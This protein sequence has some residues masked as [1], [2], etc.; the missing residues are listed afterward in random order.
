MTITPAAPE[1]LYQDRVTALGMTGCGKSTVM[2]AL[3]LSAPGPLLIVDPAD[4]D[5]TAV[6]G[7]V[8]VHGVPRDGKLTEAEL[9]ALTA[10]LEEHREADRLRF[11]PG[12]PERVQE[13]QAVYAWAFNRFPRRT[14]L[15]EARLAAPATGAP[16]AVT[17]Y[18]L[19]GRKRQLGHQAC[20]T[21]PVEVS[22]NLIAQ[23]EHLL[24]W[25]LP[26]PADRKLIAEVLGMDWRELG[27]QMDA[28]E[29]ADGSP[30]ATGFLWWSVRNP[31][32]LL[33][34]PPLE[35]ATC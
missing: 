17:R 32:Q 21:R 27:A 29:K 18:L 16:P 19:W 8:T 9:R 1:V 11:V 4:S 6:P 5:A 14:W 34:C 20:H 3:A 7:A 10:Q 15:D 12:D 30:T 22:R 23:A 33:V 25:N 35:V 31:R 26:H 2:R 24:L 13:Y 28:L